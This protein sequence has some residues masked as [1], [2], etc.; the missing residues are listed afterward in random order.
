MIPV[1]IREFVQKTY[2]I[3]VQHTADINNGISNDN[4]NNSATFIS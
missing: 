2:T 4:S 1:V 3:Y